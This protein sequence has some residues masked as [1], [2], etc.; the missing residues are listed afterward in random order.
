MKHKD[1]TKPTQ[2]FLYIEKKTVHSEY[3]HC[4]HRV[5]IRH[6]VG[7]ALPAQKVFFWC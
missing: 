1:K 5:E 7:G 6:P 3:V 4:T 2:V